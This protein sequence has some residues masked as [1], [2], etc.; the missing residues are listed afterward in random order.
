MKTSVTVRDKTYTLGFYN[1]R[2]GLAH[3]YPHEE[4]IMLMARKG[5]LGEER[6]AKGRRALYVSE[7]LEITQGS[8]K[9][10]KLDPEFVNFF[11]GQSPLASGILVLY[12]SECQQ[13]FDVSCQTT[14]NGS[15]VLKGVI[16]TPQEM[17]G[18][19]DFGRILSQNLVLAMDSFRA[20]R[21]DSGNVF[22]ITPVFDENS[23]S[24]IFALPKIHAGWAQLL[25]FGQRS[26][27]Q[28]S[29][30]DQNRRT[31]RLNRP[32]SFFYNKG[33][34]IG[35]GRYVGVVSV[36]MVRGFCSFCPGE[37]PAEG[38]AAVQ[39]INVN[40]RPVKHDLVIPTLAVTP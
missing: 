34:H 20:V 10:K 30:T 4:A 8:F 1:S 3:R 2:Q 6:A 38:L 11:V 35:E 29:E 22:V 16:P 19:R 27:F 17:E 39:E 25:N 23:K 33:E 26:R 40:L 15:T 32:V 7:I 14:T 24:A 12:S 5:H 31:L 13:I 28:I 36:S 18:K 37:E 9:G 21:L